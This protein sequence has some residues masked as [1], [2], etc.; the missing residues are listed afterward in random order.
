MDV[1]G[2]RAF[3]KTMRVN[4]S[5]EWVDFGLNKMRDEGSLA[6]VKGISLNSNTRILGLSFKFNFIS[7]YGIMD[8][9]QKLNPVKSLK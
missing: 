6:I 4:N 8:I 7:D 1:N 3:E 5:L 2:A 9:L